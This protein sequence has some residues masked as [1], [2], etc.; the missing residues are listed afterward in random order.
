MI[1]R[2]FAICGEC[3]TMGMF[4]TF[5]SIMTSQEK[6][7]TFEDA[8]KIIAKLSEDDWF[9]H[10]YREFICD[11]AMPMYVE[12]CDDAEVR[13]TLQFFRV[14][15]GVIAEQTEFF[16]ALPSGDPIQ[17]KD[18]LGDVFFW[19]FILF[20]DIHLWEEV[21]PNIACGPQ[22]TVPEVLDA[23][24]KFSRNPQQKIEKGRF[25]LSAIAMVFIVSLETYLQHMSLANFDETDKVVEIV[26]DVCRLNMAKLEA[27]PRKTKEGK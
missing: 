23:L 7:I 26:L 6:G 8:T 4:T 16:D 5:M 20:N 19:V 15:C 3:A 17:I 2:L 21:S 24:E 9:Q 18:E 1:I 27:A 10:T 12:C 25:A 13:G 14:T 22:I 11:A